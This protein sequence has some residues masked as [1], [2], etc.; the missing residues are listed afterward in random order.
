MPFPTSRVTVCLLLA[1][2]F[3]SSCTTS[4][5]TE[6]YPTYDPFAPLNG[7]GT[8]VAPIQIGAVIQSTRTPG[9]TPTRVP[10]SVTRIAHNSNTAPTPDMPHT[11]PTQ[12]AYQEQY[13]V[14]PGD[15]LGNIAQYYGITLEALM[16]ANGLNEA[17][18]LSVGMVLNIPPIEADQNPGSAFKIIPDSELVY[19]RIRRM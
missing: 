9:P 5:P 6:A 12:R 11:L 19:G 14:Q 1:V 13:T 15:T 18:I 16:Q 2:L 17:S 3:G 10:L 7:S 4:S 8:Q